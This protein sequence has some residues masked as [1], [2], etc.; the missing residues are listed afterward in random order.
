MTN[1][2]ADTYFFSTLNEM[3][4][5]LPKEFEKDRTVERQIVKRFGMIG[6]SKCIVTIHPSGLYVPGNQIEKYI[7]EIDRASSFMGWDFFKKE[8]ERIIS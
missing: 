6:D 3:F 1:D 4:G 5:E 8:F 7:K 2:N